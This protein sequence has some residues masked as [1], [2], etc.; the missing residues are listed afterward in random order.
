VD[1]RQLAIFQW[2]YWRKYSGVSPLAKVLF[3]ESL[4]GEDPES[5]R[6]DRFG[7]IGFQENFQSGRKV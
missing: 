1:F 2:V 6:T 4:I 7:T 3:G 5:L